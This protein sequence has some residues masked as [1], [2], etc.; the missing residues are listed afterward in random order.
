VERVG[1]VRGDR[2]ERF[3]ILIN[4]GRP[5]K[6]TRFIGPLTSFFCLVCC[7][8]FFVAALRGAA[9]VKG[10][11]ACKNNLNCGNG[12]CVFDGASGTQICCTGGTGT[13]PICRY[14]P[15]ASCEWVLTTVPCAPCF[16][17]CNTGASANCLL[18]NTFPRSP[19]TDVTTCLNPS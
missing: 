7:L 8:T 2:R 5:M 14:S 12:C 1:S 10:D 16:Q 19:V 17:Y 18:C 9:G 11:F 6:T 4:G 13:N 3:I 15:G